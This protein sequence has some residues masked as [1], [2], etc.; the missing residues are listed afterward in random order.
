MNQDRLQNA[1]QYVRENFFPR[2]DRSKQWI[3][4]L[5]HSLASTG[6][7]DFREKKIA[8]SRLPVSENKL[9][10]IIIHEIC[11]SYT[12]KVRKFYRNTH[13]KAWQKRMLTIAELAKKKSNLDLHEMIIQHIEEYQKSEILKASD[14]YERMEDILMD[15]YYESHEF[16]AYKTIVQIIASEIG[17]SGN[18]LIEC[19]KKFQDE[20]KKAKERIFQTFDKD[21]KFFQH[22]QN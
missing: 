14:I 8:I 22:H 6:L 9:L 5:D 18:E 3:I 11:H 7:C 16:L 1:F 10:L 21:N 17:V 12:M 15:S 19:Y 13:G 2:W 20:Y 4:N